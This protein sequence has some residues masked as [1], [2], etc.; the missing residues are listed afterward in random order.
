[1]SSAVY[2][3]SG[4]DLLTAGLYLDM[5]GWGHHVFDVSRRS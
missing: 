1:M 3:R 5:P 4:D 2:E